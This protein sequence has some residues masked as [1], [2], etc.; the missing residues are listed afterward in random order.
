LDQHLAGRRIRVAELTRLGV[1]LRSA[2]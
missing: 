1:T 2:Q